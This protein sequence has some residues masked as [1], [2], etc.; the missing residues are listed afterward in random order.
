MCFSKNVSMFTLL[1]GILGGALCYSTGLPDYK[2]IGLFFAF[3][4]L[5]QGIEYLLW[6]HQECDDYNKFL[7]Y[8]GM[9]LNHL[10]PIIL[11]ILIYIYSKEKFEKNKKLLLTL[12]TIYIIVITFYSLKFKNECTM[13]DNKEH[14]NW[15]WNNKENKEIV[16]FIFL[17]CIVSFGFFLPNNGKSFSLAI[18]LSYLIS[19]FIYHDKNIVGSM[20]CFI[21]VFAPLLYYLK[22]KLL[23]K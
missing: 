21:S 15:E 9:L 18:M 4:S 22:F 7:S 13:K 10:Q 1:T 14:L 12:I 17:I 19:Y 5:M 23:Q 16:Y 11:F 2:I 6:K 20:W 8:M 3:V